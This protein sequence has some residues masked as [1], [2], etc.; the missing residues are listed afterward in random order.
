MVKNADTKQKINIPGEGLYDVTNTE[1]S[2]CVLS[3]PL[4]MDQHAEYIASVSE[5]T[6]VTLIHY[7]FGITFVNTSPGRFS[8][9]DYTEKRLQYGDIFTCLYP[10]F[11]L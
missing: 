7:L 3:D 8:N 5:K 9:S 6:H 4:K 10:G 1:K 2:G 11:V